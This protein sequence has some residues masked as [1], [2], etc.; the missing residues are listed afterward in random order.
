MTISKLPIERDIEKLN[1]ISG[2]Y[3]Y[4]MPTFYRNTYGYKTIDLCLDLLVYA[5]LSNKEETLSKRLSY[6]KTLI[7]K[8]EI[9]KS[10]VGICF[11]LSNRGTIIIDDE[12]STEENLKSSPV[13]F[14]RKQESNFSILLEK[15][16]K[17]AYGWKKKT[18]E[19]L[20][21]EKEKQKSDVKVK[22]DN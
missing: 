10:T 9:L 17:Q 1:I 12:S 4:K 18:I 14:T 7:H 5:D 21:E 6:L 15:I 16:S 22:F 11:E 20:K 3:V 8:I 19:M 2:Y 13:I